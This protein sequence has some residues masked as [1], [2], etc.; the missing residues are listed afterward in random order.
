M[1]IQ[2][3][4]VGDHDGPSV[5]FKKITCV[6]SVGLYSFLGAE[7]LLQFVNS[8]SNYTQTLSNMP[9]K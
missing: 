2:T 6:R 4:T 1:L 5:G 3:D 7:A 8:S 9:V